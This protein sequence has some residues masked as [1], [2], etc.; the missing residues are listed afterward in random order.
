MVQLATHTNNS[1]KSIGATLIYPTECLQ[2]EYRVANKCDENDCFIT[3]VAAAEATTDVV[4]GVKMNSSHE[5]VTFESSHYK[6]GNVVIHSIQQ[7]QV[8]A[9]SG[10]TV[11]PGI[12]M[13][14]APIGFPGRRFWDGAT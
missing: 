4:V 11:P 12:I 5:R 3:I 14:V 8:N 10:E 6:D 2:S 7:Y 13:F 9:R 1:W